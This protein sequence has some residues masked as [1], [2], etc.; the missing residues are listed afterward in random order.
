[1][2]YMQVDNF[3]MKC[4]AYPTKEQREK[5]DKILTGIRVAYNV[6]AYEVAH[7][8]EKLSNPSKKDES[9]RFPK[10]SECMKKEWLDHLRNEHEIIKEVPA[11]ALASS[12]Y[13]IFKDMQ[14]SWE[15]FHPEKFPKVQ[16]KTKTG[17]PKFKKNG[18][19]VWERTEKPVKVS[20][21]KWEPT[22]YSSKHPRT[23]FTVQTMQNG[24]EFTDNPKVVFIGVTGLGKVK[25]RGW[26]SDLR[27]GDAPDQTFSEFYGGTKKAFGVT[28][29]KDNCGDYWIVVKLQT[30]WKPDKSK[31]NLAPLGVDVGIKDIAITSDGK[32]YGN[33]HFKRINKVHLR[34]LSRKI[35]RRFGWSNE[36][37]R[38]EH[39]KNTEIVPSKGYERVARKK[40]LLERKI[41]RRRSNYN[42]EITADIVNRASFIGIEDLL[43]SGMMKN[44]HLAYSASDAAMSDVLQKLKYKAE[45]QRVPIIEIGRFEP[46][47]KT[48]SVCGYKRE[49]LSLS[50]REWICPECGS[51]LDRDINAARNI[52][53][54]AQAKIN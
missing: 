53:S 17:M 9:V 33:Q 25:T 47:S 7:A 49:S 41:A 32:K 12:C 20:C 13:G 6:T 51:K 15:T 30:V 26:R 19:P 11:T 27:F 40:A 45:W 34:R 48:C 5:I 22:Y 50:T 35:S 29:S 28:V 52:L 14:K 54:M 43:V 39:K 3:V 31:E 1:M 10:F 2:K 38:A 24:F 21:K 23:S 42:S 8:N 44:R 37:F 4:R 18:D 16:A 36:V 46:S